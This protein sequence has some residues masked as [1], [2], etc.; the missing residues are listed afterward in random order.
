MTEER[1]SP[2]S[3]PEKVQASLPCIPAAADLLKVRILPAEFSRL[4]GVSRQAV[5]RWIAAGKLNINPM[6][7]RVDIQSGV[8]QVLR[9]CDPG[10]LRARWLR[11]AVADV[12]ALRLAAAEA[13]ERVAAVEAE[14]DHARDRIAY[15][16]RNDDYSDCME[17]TILRLMVKHESDFR[18]TANSEEWAAKVFRLE[19]LAVDICDPLD[20]ADD[21]D[22]TDDDADAL[23]DTLA[24]EATDATDA[25]DAFAA[26]EAPNTKGGGGDAPLQTEH[27][28][29]PK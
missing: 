24:A 5:S 23:L 22:A 19:S 12:Q 6:D 15:L 4:L 25:L 29:G 9:N 11:A 10:R 14:L 18:V 16:D 1:I 27:E 26:R 17:A 13:D 3:V 28:V 21:L 2:A 7:G 20:C 8:Q